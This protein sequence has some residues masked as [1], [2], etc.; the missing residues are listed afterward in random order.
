MAIQVTF[1]PSNETKPYASIVAVRYLL[2][3]VSLAYM[4]CV[5]DECF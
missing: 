2:S 3:T 1:V 5:A 4:D